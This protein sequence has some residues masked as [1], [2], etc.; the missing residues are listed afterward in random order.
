MFRVQGQRPTQESFDEIKGSERERGSHAGEGGAGE[1]GG[2]S[3][4]RG[5][6]G[7]GH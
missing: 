7:S 2:Q 4:G 3:G 6:Q 1:H 5:Q